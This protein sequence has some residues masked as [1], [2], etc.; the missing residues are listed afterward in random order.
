M[1]I[2][3]RYESKM[4]KFLFVI[5]A[6]S[7]ILNSTGCAKLKLFR[8]PQTEK[9]KPNESK[10]SFPLYSG[11]KAHIAV[12]DFE[13]KA[14]KANNEIGSGLRDMLVKSLVN[15]NRFSVLDRQELLESETGNADDK[16]PP[17]DKVKTAD[18]IVT[19]TVIKFEPQASGG[20]D[21]IGGG[22]GLVNGNFGGLLG[23]TLN[24]AH[25]TLDI[26]LVSAA[27][28]EVLAKTSVQGKATDVNEE[29]AAEFSGNLSLD[30]RLSAY[31]NTPMEKAVQK[32]II[33]GV[34][35]ITQTISETYYKY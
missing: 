26:S 15:T 7:M 20:S 19:A 29:D 4:K 21:G 16:N 30:Q 35:Y 25:I 24:K 12:A 34:N 27:T 28:S 9:I 18:L 3:K 1:Y 31:A 11:L 2:I 22:G 8:Q 10:I 14:A 33:E 6:G 32:C 5:I 17:I 23:E 13:I